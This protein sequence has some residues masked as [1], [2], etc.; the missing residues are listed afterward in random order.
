MAYGFKSI[1]ANGTSIQID[2]DNTGRD[3][4]IGQITGSVTGTASTAATVELTYQA[5]D[6]VDIWVNRT[7]ITSGQWATVYHSNYVP[8]FQPPGGQS[9]SVSNSQRWLNTSTDAIKFLYLTQTQYEYIEVGRAYTYNVTSGTAIGG[10]VSGNTYYVVAKGTN[11]PLFGGYYYKLSTTSGGSVVQLST[12]NVSGTVYDIPP[13]LHS[14]TAQ[15][16]IIKF[17]GSKGN[18]TNPLYHVG[19]ATGT[20]NYAI[21]KKIAQLPTNPTGSYGLQINNSSNQVAFD[22]RHYTVRGTV[23]PQVLVDSYSRFG[24][25]QDSNGNYP[26]TISA[27]I[28]TDRYLY[29]RITDFT[30]YD[31]EGILGQYRHKHGYLFANSVSHIGN[32]S[33][34]STGTWFISQ[35]LSYSIITGFLTATYYGYNYGGSFLADITNL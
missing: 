10:L 21:T 6:E 14:F 17:Y 31:E 9:S 20:F 8:N 23:D 30:G 2:S 29:G 24:L 16:R 7:D 15:N 25:F 4:F 28:S 35:T 33:T 22:S 18:S 12:V 3:Q 27:P 34:S 5:G 19:G 1:A 13:G 26:S 11:D 32:R